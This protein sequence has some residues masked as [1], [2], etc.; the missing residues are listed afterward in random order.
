L[1]DASAYHALVIF[2]IVMPKDYIEIGGGY[3]FTYTDIH[4]WEVPTGPRPDSDTQEREVALSYD[5]VWQTITFDSRTYHL[6]N[7][8]LFVIRYDQNWQPSPS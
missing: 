5:S 4:K 2:P 8:N 6:A 3:G 7:G 1:E